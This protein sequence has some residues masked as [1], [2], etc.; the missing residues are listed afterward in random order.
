MAIYINHHYG[1]G[2]IIIYQDVRQSIH[3]YTSWFESWFFWRAIERKAVLSA[4]IGYHYRAAVPIVIGDNHILIMVFSDKQRGGI[5]FA[6]DEVLLLSVAAV[7]DHHSP[8]NVMDYHSNQN[9]VVFKR[10]E[11]TQGLPTF[12][13][14]DQS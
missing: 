7:T 14:I 3:A 10:A 13:T 1:L 9:V 12:L 5:V 11:D 2:V 8:V 6:L 4:T